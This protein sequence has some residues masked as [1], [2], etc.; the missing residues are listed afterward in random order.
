M[1]GNWRAEFVSSCFAGGGC[2][3]DGWPTP[4]LYQGMDR[5]GFPGGCTEG[6]GRERDSELEAGGLKRK[7]LNLTLNWEMAA[8]TLDDHEYQTGAPAERESL[9]ERAMVYRKCISELSE[10]LAGSIRLD[11]KQALK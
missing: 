10:V 9:R 7:L 11:N 8:L 6:A 1:P 3:L 5:R 2:Q 4:C